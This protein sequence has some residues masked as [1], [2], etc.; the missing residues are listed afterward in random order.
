M[1]QAESGLAC[2]IQKSMIL[3]KFYRIFSII[4]EPVLCTSEA[5]AIAPGI[6]ITH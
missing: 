4:L 1:T 2:R 3:K 5:K 6:H